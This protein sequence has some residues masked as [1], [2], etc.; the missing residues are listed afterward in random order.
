M[1]YKKIVTTFGFL[2]IVLLCLFSGVSNG[3]KIEKGELDSRIKEIKNQLE[4]KEEKVGKEKIEKI[5]INNLTPLIK[6]GTLTPSVDQIA[7]W[8]TSLQLLGEIGTETTIPILEK[9]AIRRYHAEGI[10]YIPI[11]TYITIFSIQTKKLEESERIDFLLNQLSRPDFAKIDAAYITLKGIGLK[12][13]PRLRNYIET[14]DGKI[15][16]FEILFLARLIVYL[17]SKKE[18]LMRETILSSY[19]RSENK[20][21]KSVAEEIVRQRER[22]RILETPRRSSDPQ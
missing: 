1:N 12:I 21:I 20:F 10:E 16:K 3:R 9:L 5:L 18:D 4:A 8:K 2:F 7:I 6:W 22:K 15:G 14:K 19:L 13:Y 17:E 11:D